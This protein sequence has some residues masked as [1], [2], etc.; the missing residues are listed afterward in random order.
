MRIV[1]ILSAA[2]DLYEM[3]TNNILNLASYLGPMMM[4]PDLQYMGQA[5]LETAGFF[6]LTTLCY[7]VIMT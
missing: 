1:V 4:N 6:L 5:R 2:K 7:Q 3:C